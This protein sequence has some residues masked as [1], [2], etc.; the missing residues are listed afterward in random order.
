MEQS[1]IDVLIA[2]LQA[3]YDNAQVLADEA[4]LALKI[5]KAMKESSVV[6]EREEISNVDRR[7]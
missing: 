2:A 1:S 4:Q 6:K 3:I 7:S 5:A